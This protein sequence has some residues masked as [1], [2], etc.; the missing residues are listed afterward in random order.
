MFT[1]LEKVDNVKEN[2]KSGQVWYHTLWIALSE[3]KLTQEG[4]VIEKLKFSALIILL[5]CNRKFQTCM[6][7]QENSVINSH[8]AHQYKIINTLPFL[9]V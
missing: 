6:K 7:Y 1:V 4:Y 9:Y 8:H 3:K 5:F 2:C